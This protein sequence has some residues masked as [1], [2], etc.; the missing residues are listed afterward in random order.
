[1]EDFEI[2]TSHNEKW[3]R[4]ALLLDSETKDKINE[5]SHIKYTQYHTFYYNI[6]YDNNN[7]DFDDELDII[8]NWFEKAANMFYKNLIETF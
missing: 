7:I 5:E 6:H 8:K 1:M 3:K 4:L 2:I